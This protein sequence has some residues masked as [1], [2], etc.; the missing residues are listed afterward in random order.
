VV[1]GK[2]SANTRHLWEICQRSRPS[3]LVQGPEDLDP[4]WLV[5]VDCVGITAGA[6][7]P[8]YVIAE[9]EARLQEL[10]TRAQQPA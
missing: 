2:H 4:A 10:A 7:T 1:G 3:Y 8:D 5:G 9:V 6:S